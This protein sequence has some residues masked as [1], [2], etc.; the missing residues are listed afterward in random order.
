MYP[1]RIRRTSTPSGLPV[2]LEIAKAHLRVDAGVEDTLIEGYIKA[3]GALWDA[4]VGFPLLQ[5]EYVASYAGWAKALANIEGATVTAVA[6]QPA[7]TA[8]SGARV[9]LAAGTDYV[10]LP[11]GDGVYLLT[12]ARPSLAT[13]AELEP[14]AVTFTRGF[15]DA[16]ALAAAQPDWVT[17][18]LQLVAHQYEQRQ[19]VTFGNIS[20]VPLTCKQTMDLYRVPAL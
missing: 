10:P 7:D 9:A 13:S 12:T 20:E 11:A 3:A 5:T 16:A 8:T 1:L 14:V 17:A 15:A 18:L 19:P 4:Y 6:Y 2:S